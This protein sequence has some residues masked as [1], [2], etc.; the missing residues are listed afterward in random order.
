MHTLLPHCDSRLKNRICQINNKNNL[1][2]IRRSIILCVDY[3]IK[4]CYFSL[5][6]ILILIYLLFF[7]KYFFVN[8]VYYIYE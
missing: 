4:L 7:F 3:F 2:P 1:T 8:L 5:I 6:I